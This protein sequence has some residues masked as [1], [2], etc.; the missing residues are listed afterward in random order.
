MSAVLELADLHVDFGGRVAAVR[1]VSL[2]VERGQTHCVV[3]ESGC[4]KS[5]SALAVMNLLA[6]NARR[7]ADRLAFQGDDLL[8]LDDAGMARLRGNA[9]AII[10]RWRRPP[11][12]W[13]GNWPSRMPGAVMPTRASR[14]AARSVAARWLVPLWRRST[15]VSCEPTV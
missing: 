13:C 7:S 14:S 15:S 9:M 12:S 5:V 6:R 3:G 11:D 10:T 1:G 2:T 8:K 4:G